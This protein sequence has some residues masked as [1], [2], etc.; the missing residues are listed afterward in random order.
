MDL[1]ARNSAINA[2]GRRRFLVSGFAFGICVYFAPDSMYVPIESLYVLASG[3]AGPRGASVSL[4]R[5][6][7]DSEGGSGAQPGV[8]RPRWPH[9]GDPNL[10][11]VVAGPAPRVGQERAREV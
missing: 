3:S 1:R 7:M 10:A 5:S 8:H 4:W 2:R 6:A 11:A 9:T